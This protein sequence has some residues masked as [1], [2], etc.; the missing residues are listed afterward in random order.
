[1]TLTD[2]KDGHG[3][4]DVAKVPWTGLHVF[5]AGT[6]RKGAVDAAESAVVQT[7]NASCLLFFVH[8]L[9]IE[10]VYDTHRFDL[11]R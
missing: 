6:A 4:L 5:L 10:N 9:W 11:L 1:M 8:G 3:Q 7:L 2:M